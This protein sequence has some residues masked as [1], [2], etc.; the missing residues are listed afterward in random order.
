[1]ALEH[2]LQEARQSAGTE[3]GQ[4]ALCKQAFCC[5]AMNRTSEAMKMFEEL[6]AQDEGRW[7]LVAACQLW[8]HWIRQN[9]FDEATALLERIATHYS[10][11]QLARYV[12]EDARTAI[13][14]AYQPR[15]DPYDF[16]RH[17]RARLQ[18]L[19]QLA[20]VEELFNA[21]N[22]RKCR[23][24][25]FLVFAYQVMGQLDK[26]AL[27]GH[28]LVHDPSLPPELLHATLERL[29]SVLLESNPAD[30]LGLVEKFLVEGP[31]KYRPQFLFLLPKRASA[32]AALERWDLAAQDL[33]DYFRLAVFDKKS[34][35]DYLSACLLKGFLLERG[36]ERQGAK[37]AWREGYL[38]VKG[39]THMSYLTA[40]ILG[41]LTKELTEEDTARIIESFAAMMPI[42]VPIYSLGKS[43]LFPLRDLTL[44]LRSMWNTTRG[45][46]YA[47][48]F[49]FERMPLRDC[50][51]VQFSLFVLSMMQV[52]AFRDSMSAE[53]EAM[54][55]ELIQ[56]S[57]DAWAAGKIKED[58][59]FRVV[60]AWLGATNQFGWQGASS[61]FPRE[62]RGPLEYCMAHRYL[63]LGM[64]A[65][66]REFFQAA[67]QDADTNGTLERLVRARLGQ[68]ESR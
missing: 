16:Y 25:L 66:S 33:Q 68:F 47:R 1:M 54:I 57:Y 21:P 61:Q 15:M 22:E 6:G 12:Q 62:L 17:D 26:A 35:K 39:T 52:S 59:Y 38:K 36:G 5:A 29:T 13:L 41:S 3:A 23:T 14:D 18:R 50:L 45:R 30:V 67:L 20:T 65:K 40:S 19:E 2:Y 10:F 55:W 53:E 27:I 64:P 32:H 37:A 48:S 46:D 9:R 56:A 63:V 31:G 43:G 28:E 11:D 42:K 8:L 51:R 4:E 7:S 34:P 58:N 44:A 60:I 49:A 24:K